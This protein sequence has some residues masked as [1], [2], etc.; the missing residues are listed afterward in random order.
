MCVFRWTIRIKIQ[1]SIA[2]LEK[3]FCKNSYQIE[4]IGLH[5]ISKAYLEPSQA[6]TMKIFSKL[7]DGSEAVARRCSASVKQVFLKFR[8]THRETP[9]PEP[10]FLKFQASRNQFY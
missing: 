1:I 5:F 10:V 7:V 9:K 6:S 8:K 2:C 3:V 4:A